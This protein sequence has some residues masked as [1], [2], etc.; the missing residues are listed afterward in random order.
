[1]LDSHLTGHPS[2]ICYGPSTGHVHAGTQHTRKMIAQGSLGDWLPGA[3]QTGLRA[4]EVSAT[5]GI[6][7]GGQ[8]PCCH[9]EVSPMWSLMGSH[10]V[11]VR[12][13]RKR[14]LQAPRRYCSWCGCHQI[15]RS[16]RRSRREWLL[17]VIRLYPYRCEE[18]RHRF[19]RFSLSG[20]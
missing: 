14:G 18:C 16:G 4:Q 17:R 19:L 15:R 20:R 12:A 9:D 3:C 13:I 8:Q 7:A 5:L 11:R 2:A 6:E 1:M 10:S